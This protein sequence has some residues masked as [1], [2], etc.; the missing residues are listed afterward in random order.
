MGNCFS[1][2]C[3][4]SFTKM[5]PILELPKKYEKELTIEY[6]PLLSHQDLN[7]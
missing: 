6:V 2:L 3:N 5:K 1:K 4:K 7:I